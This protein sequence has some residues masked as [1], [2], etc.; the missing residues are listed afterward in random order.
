[1]IITRHGEFQIKLQAGDTVASF[2]PPLKDSKLKGAK[3]GADVAFVSVQH[4]DMNGVEE[5]VFGNRAPFIVSGPGE[6]E[7]KGIFAKGFLSK[8]SYKGEEKFNTIYAISMDGMNVVHLGAFSEEKIP[9]EALEAID[10]VDILI[11]HLDKETLSP[12]KASK[13]AV[14]LEPKLII[15][16]GDDSLQKQFAKEVG[17]KPEEMEKLTLKKKDLDGKSNAVV[18]L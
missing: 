10:E 9:D 8:T 2:N 7:V 5:L 12:A 6:Y 18:F 1:M 3:F 15:P 16:L 14:F 11:M 13:I 17:A 4:E